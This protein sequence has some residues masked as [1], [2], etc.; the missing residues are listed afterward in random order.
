MT[1]PIW[2]NRRAT[3]LVHALRMCKEYA[4]VRRNLSIERIADRMGVSHES[5]YKWLA[6]GKL[7]AI[8][9]PSYELTC[10]VHYASEWLAASA[11]R[12]VVPMPKG[13]KADDAELIAMNTSWAAAFQ[14]LNKFYSAPSAEAA[15]STLGALREHMAQVAYHQANVEQFATPELDFES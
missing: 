10:G 12:L 8:L 2:K 14:A 4:Q 1:R 6:T 5:L 7:P 11:G 9:L 15:E 13:A 3:S